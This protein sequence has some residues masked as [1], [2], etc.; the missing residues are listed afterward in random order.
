MQQS[1]RNELRS[2]LVRG[3]KQDNALVGTWGWA[4]AWSDGKSEGIDSRLASADYQDILQQ[5]HDLR[6]GTPDG[7]F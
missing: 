1:D 2:T 7:G 5:L 3:R 4:S 6:P